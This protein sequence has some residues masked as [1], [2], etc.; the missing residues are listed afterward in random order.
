MKNLSRSMEVYI[1]VSLNPSCVQFHSR[2]MRIMTYNKPFRLTPMTNSCSSLESATMMNKATC[3]FKRKTEQAT[4]K[5]IA[6]TLQKRSS[7]L[8]QYWLTKTLYYSSLTK[9]LSVS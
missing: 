3:L 8:E 5:N 7:L 4:T 1:R 9:A 6:K 2:L